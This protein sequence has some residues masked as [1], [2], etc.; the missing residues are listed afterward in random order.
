LE[1]ALL[2]SPMFFSGQVQA[3]VVAVVLLILWLV[4]LWAVAVGLFPRLVAR[5]ADRSVHR[6]ILRGVVGVILLGVMLALAGNAGKIA[7]GGARAM[8]LLL[9]M[10]YLIGAVIG[11]A[12]VALRIGRELMPTG[13][14]WVQ[15]TRGGVVLVL[16]CLAPVIGWFVIAPLSFG[17]GFLAF[18]SAVRCG[19]RR[20]EPVSG[21]G[22]SGS[23]ELL[24]SAITP[25]E[26]RSC[27]G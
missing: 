12:G 8:V 6:P 9:G 19:A 4:A 11:S 5:A 17:I 22:R 7:N 21:P 2:F 1:G 13:T 26:D 16:G 20:T 23:N 15:S 14:L 18:V 3:F 24:D 27:I 25:L 10:L